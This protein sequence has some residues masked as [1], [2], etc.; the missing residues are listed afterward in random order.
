M[1]QHQ[2]IEDPHQVLAHGTHP[3]HVGFFSHARFASQTQDSCTNIMHPFFFCS[4]GQCDKH[5]KSKGNLQDH[6]QIHSMKKPFKCTV[7]TF[8]EGQEDNPRFYFCTE[9]AWKRHCLDFHPVNFQEVGTE[10]EKMFSCEFCDAQFLREKGLKQ[11]L[12]QSCQKNPEAKR[13][14]C[15]FCDLFIKPSHWMRHMKLKH[16]Y[17]RK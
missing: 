5:L 10:Q 16:N 14:K 13:K 2:G 9:G 12:K 3:I 11:H 4:C 8:P 17:R 7:C 6:M 1:L 15:L